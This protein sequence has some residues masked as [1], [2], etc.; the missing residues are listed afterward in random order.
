MTV[1][2]TRESIIETFE[3]SY[4]SRRAR[5]AQKAKERKELHLR[6]AR[7]EAERRRLQSEVLL[8]DDSPADGDRE[9][10]TRN[11]RSV[12]KAAE[13]AEDTMPTR[14]PFIPNWV[15]RCFRRCF[16]S[17]AAAGNQTEKSGPNDATATDGGAAMDRRAS[18]HSFTSTSS[19]DVS[20]R[21]LKEQLSEEERQEFRTKL[22]VSVSLFVVF[23]LGG[24]GIF[25][26]CESWTF[27]NAMWFAYETF[28]TIGYG[29]YI[30]N[31]A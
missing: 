29:D 16:R 8:N 3:N 31:T 5:L 28:S 25:V 10:G 18:A 1:A 12:A 26:A 22:T 2:V 23:W 30:P 19:I 14:R 21:T 27:G 4:R 7:Q 9:K 15:R 17:G 11:G 20:F 6:R 24:A 13:H